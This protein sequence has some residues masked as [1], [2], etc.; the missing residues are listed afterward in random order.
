[1]SRILPGERIPEKLFDTLDGRPLWSEAQD[2][3]LFYLLVVY[4][5]VQCSYCKKQLVEIEQRLDWFSD[6]RVEVMAVS[7]DSQRRALQAKHDWGLNRLR[8]GFD[9]AVDDARKLG[10]FIS[11]AR[12]ETE[13]PRFSEPGIFLVKPDKTLFAAW[14][15]SYPFAR[16]HLN[17]I[18]QS[19]DLMIEKGLPLRGAQSL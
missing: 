12:R 13:M 17:E 6:R 9:L 3:P 11:S 8:L 1:M 2:D 4:R 10:L 16:P 18:V 7:A 5:G 19:I 15:S 14:I